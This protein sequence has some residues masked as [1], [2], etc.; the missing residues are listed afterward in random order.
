MKRKTGS[1]VD[2]KECDIVG[3]ACI[4]D[5]GSRRTWH[6]EDTGESQEMQARSFIVFIGGRQPLLDT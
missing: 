1:G 3:G 6:P 5:H 2:R 4:V